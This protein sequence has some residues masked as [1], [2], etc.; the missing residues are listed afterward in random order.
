[1]APEDP[2]PPPPPPTTKKRMKKKRRKK[3]QAP[4]WDPNTRPG[5]LLLL[6]L[7]LLFVCCLFVCLFVCFACLSPPPPPPPPPQGFW[8]CHWFNFRRGSK[9][10]SATFKP[11]HSKSVIKIPGQKKTKKNH[12]YGNMSFSTK[13][14]Y[15]VF[16][17][18][19]ITVPWIE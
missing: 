15:A 6:L 16:F 11:L 3:G 13:D 19:N 4:G 10:W 18:H 1:M 5:S 17:C 2:H 12:N 9:S 7:L 14:I 8:E